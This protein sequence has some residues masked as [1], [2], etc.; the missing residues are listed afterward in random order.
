[1]G[2]L[3]D[4]MEVSRG[5]YRAFYGGNDLGE[6]ASPPEIKADYE[7]MAKMISAILG[8]YRVMMELCI[9]DAQSEIEFSRSHAESFLCVAATKSEKKK[10]DLSDTF[11][12]NCIGNKLYLLS[13][14]RLKNTSPAF[15]PDFSA[16][17]NMCDNLYTLIKNRTVL[18]VKSFNSSI[19]KAINEMSRDGLEILPSGTI[20]INESLC[21][22]GFLIETPANVSLK[23]PLIGTIAQ[24]KE[25]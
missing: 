14:K 19:E 7:N 9:P 13:F 16:V 3:R 22:Q 8:A 4:L 1:M 23:L 25:D 15:M 20:P 5:K 11:T 18:S 6:L 10:T 12:Q 17:R 24:S 2:N 21:M